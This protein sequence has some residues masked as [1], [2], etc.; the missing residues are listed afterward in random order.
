M[1]TDRS[2]EDTS[3]EV[4]ANDIIAGTRSIDDMVQCERDLEA[5]S[6]AERVQWRA[7]RDELRNAAE[8]LAAE[9]S[10][11]VNKIIAINNQLIA[12][13]EESQRHTDR[14]HE[15]VERVRVHLARQLGDLPS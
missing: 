6:D 15:V 4:L 9:H 1:T 13:L 2:W 12:S 10:E 5:R 3:A 14:F 8:R 11:V 7:A